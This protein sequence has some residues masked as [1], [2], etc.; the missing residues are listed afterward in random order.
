[1][2]FGSGQLP[3]MFI[4]LTLFALS[5]S[6]YTFANS[7]PMELIIPVNPYP[8]YIFVA[9]DGRLSGVDIEVIKLLSRKVGFT[10]Q[11]VSCPIARCLHMMEAGKGDIMLALAISTTRKEY[12]E[13]LEPGIPLNPS[14]IPKSITAFY[15][16]NESSFK[17]EK[18]EDLYLL[19]NIGVK[20]KSAYFSRF[21]ND[22]KLNKVNVNNEKQLLG[23]LKAKRIDA[24]IG[25]EHQI[26]YL[27]EKGNGQHY[28]RKV[29]FIQRRDKYS[30]VSISKK[31]IYFKD[32]D[33]FIEALIELIAS[34]ELQNVIDI[35]YE[36]FVQK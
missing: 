2:K 13:F 25:N 4:L 22:T 29:N 8:P 18:Y 30:L 21:D 14:F 33:K 19:N 7:K 23:M 12:V 36:K 32:K 27:I 11:L 3:I 17:I 34:K 20:R 1:M 35:S 6:F 10:Y 28:F 31:S 5:F 9:D 16:H 15:V 26:D 24:L